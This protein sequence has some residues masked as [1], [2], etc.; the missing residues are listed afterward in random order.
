MNSDRRTGY[1]FRQLMSGMCTTHTDGLMQVTKADCCCTMGAA[2]GPRCE[3][4]PR[5]G[6]DEYEELCLEVGY[7]VD[8]HGKFNFLRN[9]SFIFDFNY[10][11]FLDIDECNTI[12][13]LCRNGRCINTLGSY[14]CMCNKG[15]RPDHSGT[16]CIGT[17]FLL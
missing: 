12:P 14:R 6:T 2:W 17:F 9:F 7:S 11:F 3:H 15:Y 13:N 5:K 16:R 10:N 1:C 4:C 8:G